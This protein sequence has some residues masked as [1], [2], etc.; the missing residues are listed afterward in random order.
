MI[1][2]DLVKLNKEMNFDVLKPRHR[3]HHVHTH[4]KNHILPL[5]SVENGSI[6]TDYFGRDDE[7]VLSQV[8]KVCHCNY[9]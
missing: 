9:I 2:F 5:S 7:L 4:L 3:K 6:V 8:R 1:H